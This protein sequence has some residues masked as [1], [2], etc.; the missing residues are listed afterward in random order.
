MNT[1]LRKVFALS[2]SKE[3]GFLTQPQPQPP[4][5][6]HSR[7]LPN[8]RATCSRPQTLTT[9]LQAIGRVSNEVGAVIRGDVLG[10]LRRCVRH[11]K[12]FPRLCDLRRLPCS[13]TLITDTLRHHHVANEPELPSSALGFRS[14]RR[15]L[16][17]RPKLERLRVKVGDVGET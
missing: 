11:E 9:T 15:L 5:T 4:Y 8:A 13:N 16:Y 10:M 12:Q 17:L 6:V 7:D 1:K 2:L 3:P 14:T